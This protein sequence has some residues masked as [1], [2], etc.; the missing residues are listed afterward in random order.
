MLVRLLHC[1]VLVKRPANDLM[2][3]ILPWDPQVWPWPKKELS[4][5]IPYELITNF[6]STST[7]IFRDT[8]ECH[9]VVGGEITAVLE[10]MF[11]Q[12]A[13]IWGLL[14]YKKNSEVFVWSDLFNFIDIGQGIINWGLE[15]LYGYL[16]RCWTSSPTI[17]QTIYPHLPFAFWTHMLTSWV[18][19]LKEDAWELWFTLLWLT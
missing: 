14:D 16:G 18:P 12:P 10:G 8:D 3:N 7:R 1:Q 5:T 9:R 11:W 2:H 15:N 13:G 6:I 17:I 19:S 4:K